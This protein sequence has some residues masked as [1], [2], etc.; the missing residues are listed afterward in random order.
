MDLKDDVRRL[1]EGGLIIE[2][3]SSSLPIIQIKK[4]RKD[5]QKSKQNVE[6][7]IVIKEMNL[8]FSQ[9][10]I[11]EDHIVRPSELIKLQLEKDL[12]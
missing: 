4:A 1:K 8:F 12:S 3:F 7:T 2:N 11:S 5:A 10:N 6:L 9:L